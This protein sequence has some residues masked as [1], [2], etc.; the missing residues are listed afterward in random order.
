[1]GLD[2]DEGRRALAL[3]CGAD[4]AFDP[5]AADVRDAVAAA[6]DGREPA[7]VIEATG[8]PTAVT[9]AF[10]W[11]AEHG[12]VVLLASTRGVT[13]TNFYQDVHRKGLTVLGAHARMVPQQES[14]PGY[15]TLPEDI[16][17]SLRLIAQ[18]RLQVAPLTSEVFS[19]RDAPK[20][21]EV[22]GSWRK[23]L[24][25]MVLRWSD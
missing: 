9:E 19:W 3:R 25:G 15:W 21:Y 17:T 14:S 2:P 5:T 20:A 4:A 10:G 6:T 8:M 24:L 18:G 23:D 12:R 13:E 16:H 7:V 22:L 1:M 11:A